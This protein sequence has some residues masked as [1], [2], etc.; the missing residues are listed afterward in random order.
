LSKATNRKL[1]GTQG[2]EPETLSG[3][4]GLP[5]AERAAY[6]NRVSQARMA[7]GFSS[8]GGSSA[9]GTLPEAIALVR[10]AV[11]I[12]NSVAAR[13][14]GIVPKPVAG[15]ALGLAAEATALTDWTLASATSCYDPTDIQGY[16]RQLYWRVRTWKLAGSV[17]FDLFPRKYGFS[18]DDSELPDGD[19]RS[20][21]ARLDFSTARAGTEFSA[22]FGFGRSR[23]KLDDELRGYVGPSASI[24]HAFSLLPKKSPLTTDGELNV[25]DGEMPPRLVIGLSAAIQVAV[26]KRESQDTRFNSVKI[27]PHLD[28]LINETLSFRLGIPVNGEIVVREKKAAQEETPTTPAKP[29]VAEKR[30]LQWTVPVAIV[31]VLKL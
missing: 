14:D 11:Q 10:R 2:F 30:A 24:A 17:S 22:G 16:F 31:A 4:T 12:T 8:T 21:E 7:C 28:F 13:T 20:G 23:E 26:D 18:P 19:V 15:I 29:A 25:K 9:A 5:E 27:Q 3:A 6:A 1:L